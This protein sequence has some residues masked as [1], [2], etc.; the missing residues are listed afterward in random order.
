MAAAPKQRSIVYVPMAQSLRH[1]R[2]RVAFKTGTELHI[3]KP[4]HKITSTRVAMGQ[5]SNYQAN[6][7][8]PVSRHIVVVASREEGTRAH[9]TE[10]TG[11]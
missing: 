6:P 2:N 11:H 9:G 10:L 3:G 4:N 5:S 8:C 1:P 7:P